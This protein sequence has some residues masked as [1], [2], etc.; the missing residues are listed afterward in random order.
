[1]CMCKINV[2]QFKYIVFVSKGLLESHVVSE[3]ELGENKAEDGT[4]VSNL[5]LE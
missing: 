2:K 3:H 5:R 4:Y 1:M